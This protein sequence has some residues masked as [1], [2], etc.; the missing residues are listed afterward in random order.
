MINRKKL[1]GMMCSTLFI[2]GCANHKERHP[3]SDGTW[4]N[5]GAP[6]KP[7]FVVTKNKY[8]G[9]NKFDTEIVLKN[10]DQVASVTLEYGNNS[11]CRFNAENPKLV[12]KNGKFNITRK[13]TY[14]PITNG[15]CDTEANSIVYSSAI[16]VMNDGS[17]QQLNGI[18][19]FIPFVLASKNISKTEAP[20]KFTSEMVSS[21]KDRIPL[22][23]MSKRTK[24][25]TVETYEVSYDSTPGELSEFAGIVMPD[26]KEFLSDDP[27]KLVDFLRENKV[28]VDLHKENGTKNHQILCIP[29]VD[30]YLGFET[31]DKKSP[32]EWLGMAIVKLIYKGDISYVINAQVNIK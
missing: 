22:S 19:F 16:A 2:F 5:S 27:S 17:V 15:A 9:N 12:L 31:E 24:E 32:K 20:I 11:N 28:V 18:N 29:M 7:T 3:S 14:V 30:C 13:L 8:L 6:E 1:I 4:G 21:K 23:H 26:G 10:A 25:R